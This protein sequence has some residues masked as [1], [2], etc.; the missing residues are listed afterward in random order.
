[1]NWIKG[2]IQKNVTWFCIF[3][4]P[5][6]FELFVLFQSLLM[7]W[8]QI[9]DT[10]SSPPFFLIVL[11]RLLRTTL[12]C[13]LRIPGIFKLIFP[14]KSRDFSIYFHGVAQLEF[15]SPFF[16]WKMFLTYFL[17]AISSNLQDF[18]LLNEIIAARIFSRFL[19]FALL[20][21]ESSFGKVFFP[22]KIVRWKVLSVEMECTIRIFSFRSAFKS[23]FFLSEIETNCLL[24][25][26]GLK[27]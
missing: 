18:F 7:L 2:S 9:F 3:N 13:L 17:F 14:W 10:Y 23:L 27:N 20:M 11:R 6:Y 4:F 19:L 24:H 8:Y 15:F 5:A 12:K 1:M 21:E 22:L 25:Y 26:Y 16:R